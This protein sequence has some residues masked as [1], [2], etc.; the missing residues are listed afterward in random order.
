[1]L[2]EQRAKAAAVSASPPLRTNRSEEAVMMS[3]GKESEKSFDS[4]HEFKVVGAVS[5]DRVMIVRSE[6]FVPVGEAF[7]S[8]QPTRDSGVSSGIKIGAEIDSLNTQVQQG[9]SPFQGMSPLPSVNK[10][11]G[12]F[13]DMETQSSAS[14]QRILIIN[15][16]QVINLVDSDDEDGCDQI[17]QRTGNGL[18]RKS[19]EN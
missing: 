2:A 10:E 15:G 19:P 5:L 1:M 11:K 3:V 13:F 14:R 9:F 12:V 18:K 8:N 4:P 16:S 7:D 6:P 17:L